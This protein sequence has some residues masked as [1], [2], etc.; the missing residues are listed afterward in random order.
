MSGLEGWRWAAH[1]IRHAL[2]PPRPDSLAAEWVDAASRGPSSGGREKIASAYE[3]K[4]RQNEQR[5]DAASSM[6]ARCFRYVVAWAVVFGAVLWVSL[7][8][9]RI[10]PWPA[11]L[12]LAAGI[13]AFAKAHQW[14]RLVQDGNCLVDLYRDRLKRVRHQWIGKGD[15]GSDLE[16]PG[17]LSA[18]DLDLFGEGSL[19]EL[20]CDVQ[21]PAGREVLAQWLQEP[22]QREEAMSRQQ[23]V[24]YLR[25]HIDLR[26]KL[27]LVRVGNANE[28][29]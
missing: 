9:H 10:S 6:R 7:G 22:A 26:E 17:H 2:S 1:M 23:S 20:L 25:D 15:A 18:A 21:T 14:K 29:S 5:R 8:A 16:R 19:F 11:V 24:R 12:P 3:S 28:Y 27:A 4:I 13:F